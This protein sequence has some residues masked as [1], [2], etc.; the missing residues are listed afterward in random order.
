MSLSEAQEIIT[1]HKFFTKLNFTLSPTI[2]KRTAHNINPTL[3]TSQ[4]HVTET[5][6][7]VVQRM[8]L[9]QYCHSEQSAMKK[10]Q[11]I[12]K[13]TFLTL[14]LTTWTLLGAFTESAAFTLQFTYV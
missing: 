2:G 11:S 13:K 14:V 6:A 9:V 3:S 5:V 12:K 7:P 8:A 4:P 1:A 10:Y